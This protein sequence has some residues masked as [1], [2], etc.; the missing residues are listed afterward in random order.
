MYMTMIDAVILNSPS[1]GLRRKKDRLQHFVFF[2]FSPHAYW[3]SVYTH[4][5]VWC[6]NIS[7]EQYNITRT[8]ISLPVPDIGGAKHS[9]THA[10][11]Y[12]YQS[13]SII[14]QIYLEMPQGPSCIA[15]KFSKFTFR[16]IA[17]NI[18]VLVLYE[19][20]VCTMRD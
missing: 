9:V 12:S 4:I 11:L 10:S 19:L 15:R 7:T 1:C 3:L 14:F 6:I 20:N 13:E 5:P 2:F 8:S 17:R 16:G 18:L